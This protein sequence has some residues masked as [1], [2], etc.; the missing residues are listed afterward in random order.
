M[1]PSQAGVAAAI[2]ST[3]RQVGMTL[4]VAVIGAISCGTVSGAIGPSFASATHPGWWISAGLGL[5]CLAL[6]V[7]TTTAWAERTAQETA[8]RFRDAGPP[9]ASPPGHRYGQ[10]ELAAR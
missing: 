5:V 1:P 6:G 9:S 10:R 2:A 4:G 8:E 3:S 7:L